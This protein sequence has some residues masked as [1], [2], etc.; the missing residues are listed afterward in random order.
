[1]RL[2]LADNNVV[3]AVDRSQAL[4]ILN[5]PLLALFRVYAA[6]AKV[7]FWRENVE[8]QKFRHST[9]NRTQDTEDV[10]M[11]TRRG[12]SLF[13]PTRGSDSSARLLPNFPFSYKAP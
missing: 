8:A 3:F 1:M 11:K 7:D 13:G 10:A 5:K 4:S 6:W 9:R 12:V 2:V